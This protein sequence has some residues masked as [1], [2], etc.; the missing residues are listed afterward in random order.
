MSDF[1]PNWKYGHVTRDGRKAR[2]ICTDKQSEYPIVALIRRDDV[3]EE[4]YSVSCNTEGR[5][6]KYE[7]SGQD[8]LN[9]P[10]PMR[11][12]YINIYKRASTGRVCAGSVFDTEKEAIEQQVFGG[13]IFIK[14]IEIEFPDV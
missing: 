1:D 12:G 9:A 13:A 6:Y 7:S 14:T 8:L 3:P 2:I 10:A 5:V 11:K 4:E